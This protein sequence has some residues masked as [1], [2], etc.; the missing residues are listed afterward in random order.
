MKYRWGD[1]FAGLGVLALITFAVLSVTALVSPH[2]TVG[3]YLS[4]ASQSSPSVCVY[5]ARTW[6]QDEIAYC[7]DDVNKALDVVSKANASL[8]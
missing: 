6:Q 4:H 3:Y 1:V 5:A 7:T 8:K 2:K